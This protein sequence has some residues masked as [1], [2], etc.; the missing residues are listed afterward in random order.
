MPGLDVFN[1]N[2]FGMQSLTARLLD[3][4][5]K[6][7]RIG[8]LGIFQSEGVRTTDISIERQGNT[9]V[10]VQTTARNAPAVQ[11]VK[12][13]RNLRKLSTVRVA[14]EDTVTADEVQNVRAFGSESELDTLQAEIDRRTGRMNSS[15]DATEEYHRVGALKG[16]VL[17][18]DGSTLFDLFTEFGVA[19][20]TEVDFDL[21]NAAPASGALR[22]ACTAQIR[23]VET[24]LGGLPY[25]NVHA[26]C[27][28]EFFDDLVAHPEYR[29]TYL[30]WPEAAQLRTR[31]GG[32]QVRVVSFGGIEFEEYTG[33]VG[34]TAYVAANKAHIFPVGTP[35]LFISRYAPAEY[36]ETVNTVGLPRYAIMNPDGTDPRHKRTVRLQSQWIHLCTRPR[37]LIPAKRT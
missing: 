8:A 37:V 15:V 30:N 3:Q 26:M 4:P 31:A 22:R 25:S 14:V 13:G 18:A 17:D 12:D 33:T 34:G 24:E 32:Q 21:D 23:K 11:N 1:S 9:L 20:Q 36:F 16:T 2:A 19:A 28:P 10:L 5:H 7:M 27:S 29:A 6:P 35:E